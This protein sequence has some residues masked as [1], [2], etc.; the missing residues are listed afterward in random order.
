MSDRYDG[1]RNEGS[2]DSTPCCNAAARIRRVCAAFEFQRV[3]M[4]KLPFSPDELKVIEDALSGPACF[5]LLVESDESGHG[6]AS[7]RSMWLL[8][9]F[10]NFCF[11]QL[12][13]LDKSESPAIGRL[14]ICRG[15]FDDSQNECLGQGFRHP[16][17]HV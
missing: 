6:T 10:V 1:T 5:K 12:N 16:F 3:Q 11:W 7:E 9:N 4:G 17:S 14:R 8:W 15:S 13:Q 2:G